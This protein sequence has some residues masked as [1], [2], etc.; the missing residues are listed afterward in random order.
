M[1]FPDCINGL[2]AYVIHEH[3]TS[4]HVVSRFQGNDAL[5]SQLI[6][7]LQQMDESPDD[8]Y[9][10]ETTGYRYWVQVRG[11]TSWKAL[12]QADLKTLANFICDM[13]KRFW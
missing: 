13:I 1:Q 2:I 8:W 11:G 10:Y 9:Q 6:M 4:S 12:S 3:G 5:Q 7:V